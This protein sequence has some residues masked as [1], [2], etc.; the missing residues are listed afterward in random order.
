MDLFE[1]VE[2]D[3]ATAKAIAQGLAA[4][5]AVDGVDPRELDLIPIFWR[6]VAGPKAGPAPS[7]SVPPIQPEELAPKLKSHGERMLFLK[8]AV[9]VTWCDGTISPQE[10]ALVRRFAAA[11]GIDNEALALVEESV[12]D[13]L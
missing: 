8:S 7:L 4:V 12:K 2:L 9:L 10:R 3:E 13:Y 6:A 1:E 11:L 5:S